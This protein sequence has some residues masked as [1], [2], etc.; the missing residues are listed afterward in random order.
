MC[1]FFQSIHK[2]TLRRKWRL[3]NVIIQVSIKEEQHNLKFL[4]FFFLLVIFVLVVQL[5]VLLY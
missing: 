2:T 3:R 4:F 1:I 5:L